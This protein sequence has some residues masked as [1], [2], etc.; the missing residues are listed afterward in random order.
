MQN[1]FKSFRV[2]KSLKKYISQDSSTYQTL[3]IINH[4]VL[5]KENKIEEILR[6][7]KP[8]KP[9]IQFLMRDDTTEQTIEDLK[10]LP[11]FIYARTSFFIIFDFE[12]DLKIA[13]ETTKLI[14]TLSKGRFRPKCLIIQY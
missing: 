4:N 8:I 12:N 11:A 10:Q 6:E 14:N 7:I 1:R 13:Q 2:F 3:L 5:K 9:S